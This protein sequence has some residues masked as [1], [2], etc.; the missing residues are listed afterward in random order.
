MLWAMICVWDRLTVNRFDARGIMGQPLSL[1][2][3]EDSEDDADQL[4]RV[5]R[6]AGYEPAYEIVD[7]LPTMHTA[8]EHKDWDVITSDHSMPQFSAPAAL[9]LAKE[10]RPNS[11]FIVVTGKNDL[12]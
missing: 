8:L 1:L 12:N 11:P 9:A 4:L 2:I 7:T 3:V 5:L 10:L 6:P